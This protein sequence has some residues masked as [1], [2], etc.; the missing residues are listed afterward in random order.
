MPTRC[1]TC[2]QTLPAADPDGFEAFWAAY[3]KKRSKGQAR[4]AWAKLRPDAALQERI[5][6][7]LTLWVRSPE[8]TRDGGQ[9]IP[10]P[11]TWLNGEGWEDQ[12]TSLPV[13]AA[14]PAAAPSA[15]ARGIQ[16][17]QRMKRDEG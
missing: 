16:R 7:A 11:A 8:W 4:K 2:G 12:P 6:A 5:A 13:V 10:H 15:A 17:L 14:A 9:Y 3:P 1:P